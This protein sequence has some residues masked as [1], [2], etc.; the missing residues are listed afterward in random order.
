MREG[1]VKIWGGST[2]ICFAAR[3]AKRRASPFPTAAKRTRR[4]LLAAGVVTLTEVPHPPV[5]PKASLRLDQAPSPV[6]GEGMRSGCP[7]SV[8][9]RRKGE[10]RSLVDLGQDVADAA[11]S[12]RLARLAGLAL[13][14]GPRPGAFRRSRRRGDGASRQWWHRGCARRP[15]QPRRRWRARGRGTPP[16]CP[17]KGGRA[18]PERKFLREGLQDSCMVAPNEDMIRST[19]LSCQDRPSALR[20][21]VT[22]RLPI[23]AR[24]RQLCARASG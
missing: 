7:L 22:R 5:S 12:C 11:R 6:P 13:R 16:G 20:R 10:G 17:P 8:L 18:R 19:Q 9:R 21:S 1:S 24:W 3:R 23:R 14:G 4:R 15:R 2:E